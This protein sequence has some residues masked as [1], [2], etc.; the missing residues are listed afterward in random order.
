MKCGDRIEMSGVVSEQLPNAMFKVTLKDE[1]RSSITV[2]IGA[3][4]VGE[5][6]SPPLSGASAERT[7]GTL[8]RLKPGDEV[9]VEISPYDP[10]RGRVVRKIS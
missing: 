6:N 7:R 9:I 8:L 3:L 1:K 4:R 2:H 10:T 5:V